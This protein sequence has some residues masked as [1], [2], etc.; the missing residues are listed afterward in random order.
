M[1]ITV[2]PP[3]WCEV[4]S[5]V[6][7]KTG[8]RFSRLF[9]L[10]SFSSQVGAAAMPWIQSSG[11]HPTGRAVAPRGLDKQ[12]LHRLVHDWFLYRSRECED[13]GL[14]QLLLIC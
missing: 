7:L 9:H 5:G 4:S 2:S 12:D 13:V 1:R 8:D 3:S 11:F 6:H 14:A 10:L